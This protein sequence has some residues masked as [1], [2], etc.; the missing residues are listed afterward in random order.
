[1]I[2]YNN[3][4]L[5]QVI[6]PNTLQQLYKSKSIQTLSL[7]QQISSKSLHLSTLTKG[8]ANHDHVYTNTTKKYNINHGIKQWK[9]I[10]K[11]ENNV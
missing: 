11:R 6:K 4:Q 1:M 3:I 10:E 2:K 8:L 5:I 7:T 9:Q